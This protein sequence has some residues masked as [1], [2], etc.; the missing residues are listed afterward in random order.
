METLEIFDISDV[1][2]SRGFP[3][4]GRAF[5][6]AQGATTALEEGSA[7]DKES[8]MP[9]IELFD[10]EKDWGLE[11]VFSGVNL[12]IEEGEKIGLV[13]RN[14]S[15][16]TSL[17]RIVA[18][19][20]D[21]YR[22]RVARRPGLTIAL[23]PQ[24]YEPPESMSCVEVLLEHAVALKARMNA[25]AELLASEGDSRS[26]LAEYGELAAR[27]ESLGGDGA[28]EVARRLL[29]KAGLGATADSPARALSGGEKNV[30]ALSLALA[31]APDL[32]LLDEP[33]N[34]LDFAGLAWLEDFIRG[35][36]R[37]VLMVS[38]NRSLLD[39]TVHRIVEL[40]SG[41]ASEYAGGYSEYRIEKLARAAGQGKDWQADR[42]RIE[43]LEALVRRFAEIAAARPDPA[44][45]KRLR[46]RRSQLE[47]EREAATARPDAEASRMSVAFSGP[48]SKADYALVVRGYRKAY[49]DHVLF[50]DAGFDLLAGERAA[51]VG[52]NGSGKTS[53]LRDLVARCG[54][55]VEG[56]WDRA[57]AIRVGPSMVIGYCAQEQEV[58]EGGRTVGEEF[59]ALG[60]KADEAFRLLRRYLFEPSILDAEVATLSGGERNRLQIARAVFLGANFLI[61]DEPTNHLDIE[62]REALEEGLEDFAGTILVVS[63]DRWFLE[64]VAERL[65][66]VEDGGLMSYEGSFSEYWR[67]LGSPRAKAGRRGI[68]GRSV[69]VSRT[70]KPE[71][72]RETLP[73]ENRITSLEIEK[74]K[75]ERA[76]I[77]AGAERDFSAA[78]KAAA[79]AQALSRTLERLYA[80]WDSLTRR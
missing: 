28:E 44:W 63:H 54:T 27:Y 56:R 62:S 23:V 52:P 47:R 1:N 6:L 79:K 9:L 55:G 72:K 50:E 26:A 64:K 13:G 68:E 53:F 69:S 39:R 31:S 14:G 18:G 43:R 41:K 24:R 4:G 42:K 60:A 38:H 66:L 22:G 3:P 65:I 48:A 58:F 21:E 37:A 32:L 45:G 70:G 5:F 40:D 71:A 36:R 80:E 8:S 34:H 12:K 74:E 46:A 76:S 35:E 20:D 49:G 59:I 51:L 33:G 30:L 16:K 75:L 25:L 61:L 7:E 10:V 15:G 2:T 73:L 77:R 78:G 19:I 57:E 17:L 11:P 29:A 67:D